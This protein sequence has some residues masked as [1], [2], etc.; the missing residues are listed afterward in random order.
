MTQSYF[1]RV[2]QIKTP[3]ALIFELLG[4]SYYIFRFHNANIANHN[5]WRINFV[6]H[7]SKV[8]TFVYK[9]YLDASLPLFQPLVLSNPQSS[10]LFFVSL[11]PAPCTLYPSVQPLVLCIPQSSPL[12]FVS[13]SPA[14]C[15]P[16]MLQANIFSRELKRGIYIFSILY[17]IANSLVCIF[18]FKL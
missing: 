18:N 1:C 17:A 9:V 14:P 5:F 8:V 2:F 11:S 15:T 13:L 6:L 4:Q 16:L 12:Y 3:V 7:I 10:P